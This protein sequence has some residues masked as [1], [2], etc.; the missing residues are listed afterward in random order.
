MEQLTIEEKARLIALHATII[1]CNY[2]LGSRFKDI[3]TLED[4][5]GTLVNDA[6]AYI[7]SPAE[8]LE[9]VCRDLGDG[10]R[11]QDIVQDAIIMLEEHCPKWME[12]PYV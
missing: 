2:A 4:S 9:A 11:D 10:D 7:S 6:G 8:R 5:I 1:E 3:Q 12:T